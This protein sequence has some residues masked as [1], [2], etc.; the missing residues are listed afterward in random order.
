MD[1]MCQLCGKVTEIESTSMVG[2]YCIECHEIV[3]EQSKEAIEEIK[4]RKKL[5][6]K[7]NE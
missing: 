2:W 3:I 6:K 4:E 7:K 5:R 1:D